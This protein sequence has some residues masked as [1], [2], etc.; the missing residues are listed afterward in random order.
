[1]SLGIH[2]KTAV[3]ADEAPEPVGLEV[4]RRASWPMCERLGSGR[5]A[6]ARGAGQDDHMAGEGVDQRFSACGMPST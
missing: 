5:L 1:M 3:G 6:A 2:G 4:D